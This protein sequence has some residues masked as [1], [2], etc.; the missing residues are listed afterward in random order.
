MTK[1]RENPPKRPN[2]ID[3]SRYAAAGRISPLVPVE[4]VETKAG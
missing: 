2:R 1:A 3:N 4:W